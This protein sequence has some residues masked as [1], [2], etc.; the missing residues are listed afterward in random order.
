MRNKFGGKLT[1]R[2]KFQ[3]QRNWSGPQKLWCSSDAN[4]PIGWLPFSR[5]LFGKRLSSYSNKS[6]K[7]SVTSTRNQVWLF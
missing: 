5:S 7:K 2:W 6:R 4:C 3:S 1:E